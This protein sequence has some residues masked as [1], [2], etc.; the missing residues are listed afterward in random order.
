MIDALLSLPEG[1]C[2]AAIGF[3]LAREQALVHGATDYFADFE[4]FQYAYTKVGAPDVAEAGISQAMALEAS[5]TGEAGEA[6][7]SKRAATLKEYFG[8]EREMV[9]QA[10]ARE[11]TDRSVRGR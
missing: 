8:L 9:A 2:K 4:A 6:Q 1:E 11:A 5:H 7:L 10:Q 3:V